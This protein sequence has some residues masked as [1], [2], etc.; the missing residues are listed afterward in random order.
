[1][2]SS[3]LNILSKIESTPEDYTHFGTTDWGQYSANCI[4]IGALKIQFGIIRCN[5]N[6]YY[7]ITFK[8]P[9]SRSGSYVGFASY[10]SQNRQNVT[11]SGATI[12]NLQ[13]TKCSIY[14]GG[15]D[16]AWLCIGF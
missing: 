4:S 9:F 16:Y 5:S 7:D 15:G 1:M 13:A 11:A 3:I 6:T 12:T 8:K 2:A 14:A 10:T